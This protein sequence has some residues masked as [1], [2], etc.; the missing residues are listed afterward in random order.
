[1]SSPTAPS[2]TPE[3]SRRTTWSS[4][5]RLTSPHPWSLGRSSR[6]TER[7]SRLRGGCVVD[8]GPSRN[9]RTTRD[10]LAD[11]AGGH[12]WD[13]GWCRVHQSG[14]G[15][16]QSVWTLVGPRRPSKGFPLV[17]HC[18]TRP[19]GPSSPPCSRLTPSGV[20]QCHGRGETCGAPMPTGCQWASGGGT[21]QPCPGARIRE[22]PEAA[23]LGESRQARAP[24]RRWRAGCLRSGLI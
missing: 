16:I 1:M 12:R 9:G 18:A 3:I 21:S 24:V 6:A 11:L 17:L 7:S 8:R 23:S 20:V 13:P 14:D 2:P 22:A 15:V 10:A 4:A 19:P 5:T